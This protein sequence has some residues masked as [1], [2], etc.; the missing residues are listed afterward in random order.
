MIRWK[1]SQNQLLLTILHHQWVYDIYPNPPVCYPPV[2]HSFN[3][4]I[5]GA[6]DMPGTVLGVGNIT[7]NK[8]PC[9]P[10]SYI[11]VGLNSMAHGQ[12]L[13]HHLFW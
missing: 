4:N 9:L 11:L 1:L 10:G 7:V 5:L 13:A 3:K 2:I 12:I 8:N 6:Y